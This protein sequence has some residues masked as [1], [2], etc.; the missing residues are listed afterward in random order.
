LTVQL[1][2]DVDNSEGL[3]KPNEYVEVRL[4]QGASSLLAI[5]IT[6]PTLIEGVRGVFVKQNDNFRF[7]P[8]TLGQDNEGWV[9]VTDGV[10]EGDD[11]V[12]EGVFD[13]KNALLKD[14]IAGH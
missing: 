10:V 14:S 7:I 3:L 2:F 4:E 9:E 12:I 1:R 8:V 5:P 11:V 13:L 6:A